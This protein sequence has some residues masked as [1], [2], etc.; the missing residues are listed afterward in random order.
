M[1][2]I[3]DLTS[4]GI[5][6]KSA[7]IVE[8]SLEFDGAEDRKSMA[9]GIGLSEDLMVKWHLSCDKQAEQEGETEKEV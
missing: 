2:Y 1:I 5:G 6:K 7:Y 8:I 3:Y 4:C 9:Q